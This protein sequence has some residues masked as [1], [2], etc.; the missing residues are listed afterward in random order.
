MATIPFTNDWCLSHTGEE[1]LE[2]LQNTTEYDVQDGVKIHKWKISEL[3]GV[4]DVDQFSTLQVLP[5]G[6]E[7]TA[8]VQG[9]CQEEQSLEE[10]EAMVMEFVE[11]KCYISAQLARKLS[12]KAHGCREAFA[13]IM[14]L[15]GD[16]WLN[17]LAIAAIY[18]LFTTMYGESG[19]R[20][21]AD[22]VHDTPVKV[23]GSES[24]AT[25]HLFSIVHLKDHWGVL[26]FDFQNVAISF[27]D[28]LGYKAPLGIISNF[29]KRMFAGNK[30]DERLKKWQEAKKA[31]AANKQE[32]IVEPQSDTFSC[33]VLAAH[34]IEKFINP[35]A[36]WDLYN[37][38]EKHRLRYL[39]LLSGYIS[40]EK[41][42]IMNTF[43]SSAGAH[44]QPTED[45]EMP[46]ASHG[47]E[48]CPLLGATPVVSR[49]QLQQR[50]PT[51]DAAAKYLKEW[52]CKEG[53]KLTTR[54]T[55]THRNLARKCD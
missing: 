37:S 7:I 47:A 17:D 5:T 28:S 14:T 39:K 24:V 44:N 36:P 26:H 1:M 38:P 2:H 49:P 4:I 21:F 46:D 22:I 11:L 40:I 45:F 31:P 6:D 50:F 19:R 42:D 16:Q 53:F 35:K 55:A 12:Q 29:I 30:K 8:R 9:L 33:G 3:K 54:S 32:F 51:I 18:R 34:A 43:G 27:G 48:E 41:D 20:V 10:D 13:D 25:D 15:C 23:D 52:A